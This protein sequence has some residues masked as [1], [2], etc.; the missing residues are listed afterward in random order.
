MSKS[1]DLAGNLTPWGTLQEELY[2][3][4]LAHL[5]AGGWLCIL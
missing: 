1:V 3:I 2:Y 5:E 4:K